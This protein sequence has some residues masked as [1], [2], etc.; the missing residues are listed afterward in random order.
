MKP[1]LVKSYNALA[2]GMVA[3]SFGAVLVRLAEAPAP[4]VAALRMLFASLILVPFALAS[5][6]LR[7]ELAALSRRDASLLLLSGVFLALHFVLWIS[8][9]SFTGVTSS[10]VLVTTNPLFVA[11]YA[12]VVLRER[13]ARSFWLGLALAF[14]GGAVIGGGNVVGG[15]GRW[16]GDLLALGGAMAIAGYF[17]V[18][19]RLRR[20]LS[21][22]GYVFPV[23]TCA[24]VI[25]LGAALA[26]RVPFSGFG[27][28]SYVYCFLL[29]LVC[30]LLGH[31]FFNYAL[32][33][34]AATAVT[35]AVLGEP[36]G[37]SLLA[38]LILHEPPTATEALGG[39]SILA[40]IF[41]VL[42]FNPEAVPPRGE[43][44][45]GS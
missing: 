6:K 44:A 18:G 23:Y 15:G 7:S 26:A 36:V 39:A 30:Q 24:A 27:W 45:S 33:H 10:V 31:S 32:K 22:L 2:A 25:L 28:R 14:V 42:Y 37:A 29:A 43:I 11:L 35:F 13:V 12:V 4:L 16:R 40:G 41:L 3:I 8:S 9:L 1:E 19:S 34:M 5:R 20:R 38:F 21:L 17:L